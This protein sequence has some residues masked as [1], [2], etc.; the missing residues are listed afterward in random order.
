MFR[1]LSHVTATHLDG[2]RLIGQLALQLQDVIGRGLLNFLQREL[3][4][5]NVF[6]KSQDFA[7]FSQQGSLQLGGQHLAVLALLLTG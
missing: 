7:V 1:H 5:L 6:E 4:P 2:F 3:Q